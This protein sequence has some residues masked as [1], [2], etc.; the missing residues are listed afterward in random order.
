MEYP[1]IQK[2]FR[3]VNLREGKQEIGRV[4][5]AVLL[6]QKDDQPKLFLLEGK[7]IKKYTSKRLSK[8]KSRLRQQLERAANFF[9]NQ[10]YIIPDCVLLFKKWPEGK[11]E[12]RFPNPPFQF[13]TEKKI[14]LYF[15]SLT[16]NMKPS[17]YNELGN[18]YAPATA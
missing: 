14:P 2:F 10:F 7:V 12:H 16:T 18:L 13:S 17:L 4:D 8:N 1:R 9:V 5:L 3:E 6:P 11:L 15:H